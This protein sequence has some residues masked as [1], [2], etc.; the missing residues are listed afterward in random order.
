LGHEL[1]EAAPVIDGGVFAASFLHIEP[2]TDAGQIL[3]RCASLC[4]GTRKSLDIPY[5]VMI[6]NDYFI[7]FVAYSHIH[8]FLFNLTFV[9]SSIEFHGA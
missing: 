6:I 8:P 9:Q 5:N 7:Y 4:C 3:L 1:E 2:D